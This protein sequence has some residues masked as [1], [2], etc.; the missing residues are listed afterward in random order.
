[1]AS[2][3]RILVIGSANQDLILPMDK[4]PAGGETITERN[5]VYVPGGSGA[6]A[7]LMFARLGSDCVFC[8]RIAKDANGRFLTDFYRKNAIDTRF[9]SVDEYSRTG[10]EVVIITERDSNRNIIYPGANQKLNPNDTE[11]AMT[12]LPD[13][14]FMHVGLP[15]APLI[16]ASR[17]AEEKRIPVFLDA[18]HFDP[19]FPLES[20]ENV[21]IFITNQE[22]VYDYTGCKDINPSSYIQICMALANRITSDYYVIKLKNGVALAYDNT[23]YKL[24][25]PPCDV[26]IIDLAT[27][28]D[29]FAASLVYEFL[30]C[31]NIH[32]A[33]KFANIV[34]SI[35]LSGAGASASVP[36]VEKIISFISQQ[37]I[38]FPYNK[39]GVL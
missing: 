29:T 32:H 11:Y 1:M 31:G 12:C 24:H 21:R 6:N 38:D 30:Q 9:V 17:I 37:N 33:C 19:E 7:A 35:T 10:L 2:K 15:S 26:E 4:I 27:A 25:V 5:Y 39:I 14:L 18:G 22:G 13:A 16:T 36:T 23:F 3:H 34:E 20:M 8:S 28:A